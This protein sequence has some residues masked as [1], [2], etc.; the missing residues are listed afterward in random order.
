[1]G[2]SSCGFKQFVGDEFALTLFLYISH[3]GGFNKSPDEE[4]RMN[5]FVCCCLLLV[6]GAAHCP[7]DAL[8]DLQIDL[9]FKAFD[10]AVLAPA[11]GSDV[12]GG[13]TREQAKEVIRAAAA[14][15]EEAFASQ[16]INFGFATGGRL[17]QPIR[18]SW[19]SLP[20]TSRARG[21]ATFDA[22]TL[23]PT[24]GEITLDNDGATGFPYTLQFFVDPTP[25]SDT[26]WAKTST[27]SLTFS[28]VEINIEDVRYE[29]TN[30]AQARQHSDLYSV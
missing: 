18:F 29:A 23:E 13:A 26:E 9:D 25:H 17:V 4:F 22:T 21:S 15:W 27:R 28:G 30:N 8:A 20:G 6:F 5:R 12:L 14:T 3:N 7:L 24:G 1:M 16:I 11:D 10:D 2:S 19:D